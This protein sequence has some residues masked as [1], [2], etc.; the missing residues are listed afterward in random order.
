MKTGN[1]VCIRY[2]MTGY[3]MWVDES[4]FPVI[5][6]IAQFAEKHKVEIDEEAKQEYMAL[7][8]NLDAAGI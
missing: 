7:I 5:D 1:R 8:K 6:E 2:P 3:P 4:Q